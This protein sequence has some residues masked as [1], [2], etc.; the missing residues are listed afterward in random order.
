M[1]KGQCYDLWMAL[2]PRQQLPLN[3][4]PEIGSM[5]LSVQF[6]QNFIYSSEVYEPLKALLYSSLKMKVKQI[7]QVL[8]S[9]HQSF[10][11]ILHLHR[12]FGLVKFVRTEI[13]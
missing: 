10:H 7:R 1:T 2:G 12:Y 4:R 9:G 8:L 13:P 5:R 3:S 6:K 11:R